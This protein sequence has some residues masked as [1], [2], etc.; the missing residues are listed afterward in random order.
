MV[1]NKN[2]NKLEYLN[3][4]KK[5]NELTKLEKIEWIEN[6]DNEGIVEYKYCFYIFVFTI[7]CWLNYE[8]SQ[9][10]PTKLSDEYKDEFIISF[11][12]KNLKGITIFSSSLISN[13]SNIISNSIIEIDS[14]FSKEVKDLYLQIKNNYL[15]KYEK[16]PIEMIKHLNK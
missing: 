6:I 5:L 12:D 14:E 7:K 1:I 16:I 13:F 10:Y 8:I 15:K 9:H 3:I 11:A 2:D 4:I